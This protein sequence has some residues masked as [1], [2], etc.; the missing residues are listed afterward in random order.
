MG[1]EFAE[2][3]KISPVDQKK[4]MWDLDGRKHPMP[5]KKH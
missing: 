3:R 4:Y 5:K 1:G 2:R